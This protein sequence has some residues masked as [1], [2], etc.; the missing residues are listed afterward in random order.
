MDVTIGTSDAT[1]CAVEH[2]LETILDLLLAKVAQNVD[3]AFIFLF[4]VVHDGLL[5]GGENLAFIYEVLL[6]S[7]KRGGILPRIDIKIPT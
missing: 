2:L 6:H 3:H 7:E 1:L 4:S 5:F